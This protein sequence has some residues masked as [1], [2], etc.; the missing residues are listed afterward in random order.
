MKAGGSAELSGENRDAQERKTVQGAAG[1]A[2]AEAA[3]F[4]T[5]IMWGS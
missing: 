2:D 5:A 1:A 3:E 4:K